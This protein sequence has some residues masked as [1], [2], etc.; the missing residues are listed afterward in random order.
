MPWTGAALP[1]PLPFISSS[2]PIQKSFAGG[3]R[4]LYKKKNLSQNVAGTRDVRGPGPVSGEVVMQS[5]PGSV[6]RLHEANDDTV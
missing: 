1:L 3:T 4:L 6:G 5:A 2:L